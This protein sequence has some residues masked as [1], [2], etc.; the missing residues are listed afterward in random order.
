MG[1]SQQKEERVVFNGSPTTNKRKLRRPRS[2]GQ[3]RRYRSNKMDG[4]AT[5][6]ERKK[7]K[8]RFYKKQKGSNNNEKEKTKK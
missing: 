4:L 2:A 6:A 7:L 1:A 3:L 8:S 5:R